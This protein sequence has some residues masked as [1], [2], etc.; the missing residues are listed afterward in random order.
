VRSAAYQVMHLSDT[1]IMIPGSF[2]ALITGVV[3]AL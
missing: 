2:G 1:A 3:V